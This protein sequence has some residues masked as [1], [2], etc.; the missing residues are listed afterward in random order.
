MRFYGESK[1]MEFVIEECAI[2]IIKSG[3]QQMMEGIGLPNKK[4]SER[5]EKVNKKYLEILEVDTIKHAEMKEKIKKEYLRSTRKLQRE[6][7][8]KTLQENRK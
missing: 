5:S 3:K 8:T 6:I 2:L 1:G 7:C 4:Q